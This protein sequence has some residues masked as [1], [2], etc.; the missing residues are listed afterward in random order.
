MN[1]FR[2]FFL[3]ISLAGLLVAA[4]ARA[5]FD[6]GMNAYTSGDFDTAT[7]E[8]KILAMKGEKESQ[9][10]LG[11]LYEEG[12][13]MPMDD[14]EAAYWYARAADQGYV[15]A[16]FALGQLFVHRKGERQDRMAAH[17]WFSL[18]REYG[19][20][21]GEQEMQRNLNA[22]TPDMAEMARNRFRDRRLAIVH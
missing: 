21:L 12:Q 22:M 4:P 9:Y 2:S 3:P 20:R 13:G 6:E 7:R 16:Y 18:A 8:F 1:A 10:L 19:H 11:M 5:G 14:V 15:D 17:H